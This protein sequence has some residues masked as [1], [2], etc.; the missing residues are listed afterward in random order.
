MNH[1]KSIYGFMN[2]LL[3]DVGVHSSVELE[4]DGIIFVFFE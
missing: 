3:N 2:L 1:L 4:G